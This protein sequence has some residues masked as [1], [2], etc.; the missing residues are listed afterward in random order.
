VSDNETKRGEDL[1]SDFHNDLYTFN[2]T[3]R[4]WFAAQLRPP[5][6]YK[7][8]QAAAGDAAVHGSSSS[9]SSS[10][11]QQQP[12]GS[13]AAAGTAG[14]SAAVAAAGGGMS[15]GSST[16]ASG[17]N[18]ELEALLAAGQDKSSPIYQAAVRIQSR[19]RGYVVRKAYKLYQLGGVVSEIL[20][21]PAAYGLD[22]SVKNM[23]KPRARISPQVSGSSVLPSYGGGVPPG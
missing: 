23:P 6:D 15:H 10:Q 9:N 3:S 13:N 20:Y 22:M 21:S 1:S 5:K 17:I 18:R 8:Q 4:R 16:A 7:Q 12:G 19:F 11:Q 14:T 2:F